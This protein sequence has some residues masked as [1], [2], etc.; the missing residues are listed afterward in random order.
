MPKRRRK[1]QRKQDLAAIKATWRLFQQIPADT[2][3]LDDELTAVVGLPDQIAERDAVAVQMALDACGED[4]AGRRAE[5][6]RKGVRRSEE[7]RG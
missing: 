6:V 3:D 1:Y 7:W 5:R 4:F 2:K